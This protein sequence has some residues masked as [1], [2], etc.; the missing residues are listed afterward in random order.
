LAVLGFAESEIFPEEMKMRNGFRLAM[1]SLVTLLLAWGACAAADS[2]DG[3][4]RPHVL[5][6]IDNSQATMNKGMGVA[7][8]KNVTYPGT[9]YDP[10]SVY[11]ADNR[12]DFSAVAVSNSTPSLENLQCRGF[13]YDTLAFAGTYTGSGTAEAP[14]IKFG[15][16]DMA[17]QGQVYALGNYLNYLDLPSVDVVVQNRYACSI[18]HTFHGKTVTTGN[19]ADGCIGTFRLLTTHVATASNEPGV[20]IDWQRYWTQLD[21]GCS[22]YFSTL[23]SNSTEPALLTLPASEPEPWLAGRSFFFSGLQSKTQRQLI[24][25]AVQ[26]VAAGEHN[27]VDFGVMSFNEHGQ[28]AALRYPLSDL[29]DEAAFSAFLAAIDPDDFAAFPLVASPT[30]RPQ[31]EALFDAGHYYGVAYPTTAGAATA[32]ND[33]SLLIVGPLSR[34]ERINPSLLEDYGSSSRDACGYNHIVLITTGLTNGDSHPALKSVVDADGDRRTDEGVY[35]EGSHYADDVAAYLKKHDNIT[36]HVILAFQADDI[37]AHR[38]AMQGGGR[39][40]NVYDASELSRAILR[41]LAPIDS[42]ARYPLNLS[43]SGRGT[44]YAVPGADFACAAESCVQ[45]YW[46]D[47]AVT[48]TALAD[49]GSVFAGWSGVCSGSGTC[50]VTMDAAKGVSATFTNG[51]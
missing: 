28:G 16:C 17:P 51:N 15:S 19:I 25:E 20:G 47:T 40:Y 35:G 34:E 4:P 32:N 8:D 24:A 11:A 43:V 50:V 1:L 5:F 13:V 18:S 3:R 38:V 26:Q 39:F 42:S 22:P 36:T 48:L 6:V 21:G 44:V 29:R 23:C 9:T 46:S 7:Y 10:W 31:A 49:P 2:C 45:E 30:S 33:G 27:A 12:G 14:N 41:I 37:L